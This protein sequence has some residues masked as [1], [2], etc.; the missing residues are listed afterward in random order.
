M[1]DINKDEIIF[2]LYQNVLKGD[3]NAVEYI[4]RSYL[5]KA[6]DSMEALDAEYIAQLLDQGLDVDY[7]GES[8]VSPLSSAVILAD[9]DLVDNLIRRG[10]DINKKGIAG[11]TALMHLALNCTIND[12]T[13]THHR[14]GLTKESMSLA[15]LSKLLSKNPDLSIVDDDGESV[16]EY[17]LDSGNISQCL[18]DSIESYLEQSQLQELILEASNGKVSLEF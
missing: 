7:V 15:I 18:K 6:Y 1:S 4:Y 10:V 9:I 16:A 11:R 12:D 14:L 8:S 3:M 13:Y 17:F 5:T 2:D